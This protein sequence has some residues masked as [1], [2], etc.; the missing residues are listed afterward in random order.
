MTNANEKCDL[1]RVHRLVQVAK[2][3]GIQFVEEPLPWSPWD[4]LLHVKGGRDD[5]R[6][7]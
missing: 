5:E 3:H 6:G 1:P 4:G 2:D 7:R